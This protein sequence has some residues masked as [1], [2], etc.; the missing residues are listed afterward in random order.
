MGFAEALIANENA[1]AV[2][3]TQKAVCRDTCTEHDA[4]CAQVEPDAI[5]RAAVAL[6]VQTHGVNSLG[7][8][9]THGRIPGPQD[10]GLSGAFL[11]P[12]H[13]AE[14]S[15]V[16]MEVAAGKDPIEAA[17]ADP[18]HVALLAA[19]R[20]AHAAHADALTAAFADV[21]RLSRERVIAEEQLEKDRG[22]DEVRR[23]FEATTRG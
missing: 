18:A 13:I 21:A 4:A 6:H 11:D 3:D 23:V 15:R 2:L 12:A 20:D 10:E 16:G 8:V 1:L 19:A 17:G 9:L 14:I 7:Q 5:M 22:R